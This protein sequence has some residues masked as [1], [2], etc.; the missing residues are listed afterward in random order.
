[1]LV[2]SPK[3]SD[4]ADKFH[5]LSRLEKAWQRMDDVLVDAVVS[6]EDTGSHDADVDD[7][8]CL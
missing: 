2:L 4:P 6:G 8:G 3:S 5:V 7:D 1:M